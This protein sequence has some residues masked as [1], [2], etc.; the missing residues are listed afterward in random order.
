LGQP[1]RRRAP[2]SE[3][4]ENLF[5]PI[6]GD[7]NGEDNRRGRK[8]WFNCAKTGMKSDRH[9]WATSNYVRHNPVPHGYVQQW[10]DWPFSSGGSFI[11]QCGREQA[12]KIWR[13][14]PVGEHGKNRDPPE[15]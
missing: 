13:E 11:E 15:L 9:F 4:G 7:W 1:G 2:P 5:R 12:G 14:Y 8:A 3:T 10:Q 6:A